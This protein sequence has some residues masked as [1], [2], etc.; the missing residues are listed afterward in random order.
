[1]NLYTT[2]YELDPIGGAFDD[3][4]LTGTWLSGGSF[5]IDLRTEDT[6]NHLNFVPEPTTMLFFALGSSVLAINGRKQKK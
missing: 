5:N 6:I 3:G 2:D 4:L 1:M